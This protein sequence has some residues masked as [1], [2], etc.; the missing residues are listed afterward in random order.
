MVKRPTNRPLEWL[1]AVLHWL[2]RREIATMVSLAIV[3]GGVW[4]FVELADDVMEG[5]TL[6]FDKRVMTALRVEVNGKL[7]GP[8][9]PKWLHNAARDVTAL[10]GLPVL[11]MVV[12]AV[13]GLLLLVKD[14][15]AACLVA[16]TT[17]LGAVIGLVMKE[18]FARPRPD[19]LERLDEVF[20]ASFPSGHSM[21]SAIVY[22]TLGELLASFVKQ[23]RLKV[24]FLAVAVALTF[25]VGA[26]RV[27]LGVHYP[28]DVMAGWT[29]GLVW[30]TFCGLIA[31]FVK[32]TWG[33]GEALSVEGKQ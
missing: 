3:V 25:L 4:I 6:R 16:A 15:A 7:G 5:D 20:T 23:R 8:I 1:L 21:M 30:A 11:V 26:S 13:T 2:R 19:F 29:A 28:T 31:T 18:F 12:A 27:Y 24:Y 10:G 32:K 22:L 14:Y 33:A 9:G 17:V